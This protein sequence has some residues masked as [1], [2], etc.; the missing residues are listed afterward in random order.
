M[1]VIE[2]KLDIKEGFIHNLPIVVKL[3]NSE[4]EHYAV[5]LNPTDDYILISPV[6]AADGRQIEIREGERIEVATKMRGILWSG[7][8]I[9][10][11]VLKIDFE[12]IW[13]TYP[14]VLTKVQRRNFLRLEMSFPVTV[15]IY[16][17]D[18]PIQSYQ[19]YCHDLSASGIGL[20]MS[21]P[22]NLMEGQQAVAVFSYKSLD[23]NIEIHP[24][25]AM[26]YGAFYRVGCKFLGADRPFI[27]K[28]HKF[29]VQ[30]QINMKKG[31]LY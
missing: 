20:N 11:E 17:H 30:E 8:C 26:K 21:Q 13:L 27:D 28:V 29:I 4:Q 1:D 18:V 9:I 25:H 2:N 24:V 15:N 10:V 6:I 31:G 22:I 7:F 16:E 3:R 23:E 14:K 12:G 5:V 19:G